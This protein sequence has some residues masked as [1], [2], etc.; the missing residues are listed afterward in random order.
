MERISS[1]SDASSIRPKRAA[2][3]DL[4]LFDLK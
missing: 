1:P 2:P 4:I 3:P